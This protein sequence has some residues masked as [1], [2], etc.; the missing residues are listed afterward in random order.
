MRRPWRRPRRRRHGQAHL[1]TT[2][3]HRHRRCAGV[4]ARTRRGHGGG[5]RPGLV[6]RPLPQRRQAHRSEL[7]GPLHA[8]QP[9]L[10]VLPRA[11]RRLGL[12]AL[13]RLGRGRRRSQ[14][15]PRSARHRAGRRTRG[16][17]CQADAVRLVHRRRCG[18]DRGCGPERTR[19]LGEGQVVVPLRLRHDRRRLL[20][21][22]HPQGD[23]PHD[24]QRA[25]PAHAVCV[26]PQRSQGRGQC[27]VR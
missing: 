23:T 5:Q 4:A 27:L 25:V 10:Q 1:H 13:P 24:L 9:R 12:R 11:L 14:A 2:G 8:A 6:R 15:H 21:S 16:R 20:R 17:T 26:H 19:P 3:R 22:R 7:P 18:G